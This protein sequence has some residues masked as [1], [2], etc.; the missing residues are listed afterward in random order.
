MIAAVTNTS[1]GTQFIHTKT[2]S[3]HNL[4]VSHFHMKSLGTDTFHTII[5]FRHKFELK[6]RKNVSSFF[7]HICRHSLRQSARQFRGGSFFSSSQRVGCM[8][9]RMLNELDWAMR[10]FYYELV[11]V[12]NILFLSLWFDEWLDPVKTYRI[13]PIYRVSSGSSKHF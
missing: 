5:M 12:L 7:I 8:P 9:L 6:W 10:W 3:H 13:K 2:N 4:L 1:P 11:C